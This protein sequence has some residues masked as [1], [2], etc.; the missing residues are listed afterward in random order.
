MVLML[1][2]T[3]WLVLIVLVAVVAAAI[4]GADQSAQRRAGEAA[5]RDLPADR[6]PAD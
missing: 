6:Q 1:S 5:Q 2:V 4:Y 3:A